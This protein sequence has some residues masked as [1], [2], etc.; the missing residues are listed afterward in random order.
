MRTS[1][2]DSTSKRPSRSPLARRIAVY[3][4]M[5]LGDEDHAGYLLDRLPAIDALRTAGIVSHCFGRS[6]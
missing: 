6:L 3:A 2:S 1:T 5:A 4:A